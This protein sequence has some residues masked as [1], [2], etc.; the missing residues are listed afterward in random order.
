M[1]NSLTLKNITSYD[2]QGVFIN[3]LKRIN[4]FFGFNGSGKSTIAKYLN[5][6]S[7]DD[8]LRS[9]DFQQCSQ[10][11]YS[12]SNQQLLVFNEVFTE[13]NFHRSDVLK[14][15]FSLNETNDAID[16]QI[17]DKENYNVSL[18]NYV[19]K[20]KA[21]KLD[22]TKDK[23]DKQSSLLQYCW[24]K[25][26]T[27]SSFS[28]IALS[29]SGSKP[30][31]FQQIRNALNQNLTDIS[32]EELKNNYDTLF[33]DEIFEITSKIDV[34]LYR[35][36][37]NLENSLYKILYEVIIGNED[38]DIAQLIKDVGAKNWVETGIKF[39]DK[40]NNVCPFC[41]ESTITVNLIEQFN[42]YFDETYKSKIELLKKYK[43]EYESL[44]SSFLSNI[45]EIQNI[46]NPHNSLSAIYIL[47]QN[48]FN[49]NI[50]IIAE[51]IEVSNERKTITTISSLKEDLSLII[52]SIN[53]NNKNFN[54]LD[55]NRKKLISDIWLYMA[56]DCRIAIEKNDGRNTKYIRLETLA[57]KIIE[58]K[59]LKIYNNKVDIENLRGQTVNTKD[60][61]DS[62]NV[63]LQNAGFQ[64]FEI[65]EKESV[66]NISQ[67][68]LKRPNSNLNSSIFKS[69][70]EGEKN[71]I[72]FLYFYQLC[73]GTD[74]LQSNGGKKK[75]IVIDDPVS[76][77]DN[78]ALF[79]VSSLIHNIM[80]RKSHTEK[81]E[82]LNDHIQQVFILTHNLYFYKEVSFNKRPLCT[83]YFHYT[84]TKINNITHLKGSYNKSVH[85]DYSLLWKT[86]KDIKT[87][88][89]LNASLNIVIAN[90]MRRI[91]E[92]YVNF[93]GYGND[94]WAALT[95]LNQGE[96][97]YF[98]KSAFI[99]IIND[100]SHKTTALD[101]IYYQK[102]INEQPDI[103]YNVFKDIFK[104]IGKDHY[105]MMMD[106]IIE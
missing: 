6:L 37:R 10:V 54:D 84:I 23:S 45:L 40:T 5:D 55:L 96:S 26:S 90:S 25:R 8:N 81:K 11:G 42:Q 18:Q 82:F 61:V 98:I 85:D 74:N 30:N 35:Q 71:F 101:G 38:V 28:K 44:A 27:F 43:S 95:D 46:H 50:K 105:E 34:K 88:L 93:I 29:H 104:T 9:N 72:S 69:L 67:Y 76:S 2:N 4:F 31:H 7:L 13:N 99:S 21:L 41:Q 77:L 15:V 52:K 68:F 103:L 17:K 24:S 47:L 80:L 33:E 39:L 100:E 86:I 106:E 63:I 16:H 48:T 49:K 1:I 14:G 73:I 20:K 70:S 94:S 79:V 83:D 87:A 51:K 92:S 12:K 22:L 19:D 36:I 60:A 32:I 59:L 64:G 3:E 102:I 75:I 58:E 89:P 66:N 65:A 78:Q 91:I 53:K 57:S 97:T 56:N 62:I